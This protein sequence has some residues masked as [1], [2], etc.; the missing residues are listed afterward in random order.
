MPDVTVYVQAEP[1]DLPSWLALARRLEA[2]GFS[3]LVMGDHPG[4]GTSPM[5]ALGAAA[6]VTSGLQL[7]TCV[8]QAGVREA[9]HVAADAATLDLLAPGRVVLGIGAGHTPREWADIGGE[10]PS[11]RERAERLAEF[12][13]AVS[14]LL[15][16]ETV[17][18]DGRHVAL[19]DARLE[20]LP[21]SGRVRLSVGGGNPVILRTAARYGD[22]VSLSGL[23]RTLPDGHHHEVRWTRADLHRTLQL[24]RDE[25]RQAGTGPVIEALVQAVR[26]TDDRDEAIRELTARI[27]G[28][29]AEDIARTPFLLAG[30]HEEMAAQL[31]AQADEL[32]ITSYV[33]REPAVPE[34]ERVLAL[35]R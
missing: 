17:T 35:I 33:V 12:A 21:A 22:V 6:A 29:S 2:A 26:V 28:A 34:L 24:V 30:T 23:G 1:A 7:G 19:H 18:L 31:L 27:P 32:G 25:A 8:V 20:G 11:P 13:E 5:P 15:R 3:G 16:G 9:M 4:S 10:R 14:R